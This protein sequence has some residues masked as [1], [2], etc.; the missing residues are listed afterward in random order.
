MGSPRLLAALRAAIVSFVWGL[1]YGV[2][3]NI[4]S[5][6]DHAASAIQGP[7]VA[8]GIPIGS[9]N[10]TGGVFI[11]ETS[12]DNGLNFLT[13]SQMAAAAT[14][15][16]RTNFVVGPQTS[17]N[18]APYLLVTQSSTGYSLA[19]VDVA[20]YTTLY[21]T[22]TP[23]L[24]NWAQVY[25]TSRVSA[26]PVIATNVICPCNPNQGK[27]GGTEF[28]MVNNYTVNGTMLDTSSSSTTAAGFAGLLAALQWNHPTWNW[29]DIKGALRQTASK[30]ATGWN[31][32]YGNI[33]F[34]SA[35][36]I[37]STASIYLQPPLIQ[38]NSAGTNKI[39]ITIYPFRTTR[40]DHEVVYAVNPS[41]SWPIKNE[42]ALTDITNS[43]GT[44]IFTGN[45][46]SV[47][48]S[49][50]ITLALA[51]GLYDLI[52]FTTDNAGGY[53]RVESFSATAVMDNCL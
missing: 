26:P 24:Y 27:G 51:P 4:L 7:A 6:T 12:T 9:I 31:A 22:G 3:P 35:T 5:N 36:A 39:N 11:D 37:G 2:G 19:S 18:H 23:I 13:P 20:L 43:G 14:D 52:G 28:T 38:V 46:S 15:S 21:N 48:P 44:L 25:P 47:L 40:R 33:D 45:N 34:V 49:A 16:G 17:T 29:W 1:T 53:S 41:Y 30:W 50:T 32:D 8:G 42:Y 10:A